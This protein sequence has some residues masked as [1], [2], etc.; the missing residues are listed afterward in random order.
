MA[1]NITDLV[2]LRFPESAFNV[3]VPQG[4]VLGPHLFLV[5]LLTP[6]CIGDIIHDCVIQQLLYVAVLCVANA[7]HN[8]MRTCVNYWIDEGTKARG[9]S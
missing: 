8:I 4:S 9:G 3:S 2:L 6:T 7:I 5:T 1:S